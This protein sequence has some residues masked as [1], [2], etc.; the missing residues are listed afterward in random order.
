MLVGQNKALVNF[1]GKR[2]IL[3]GRKMRSETRSQKVF[4]P[5]NA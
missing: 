4:S 1:R 3:M 2:G 5:N